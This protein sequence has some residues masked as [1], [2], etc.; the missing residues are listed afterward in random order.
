[1]TTVIAGKCVRRLYELMHKIIFRMKL[2]ILDDNWY[3]MGG[4]CFGLFPPSF[5][6]THTPEEI[7]HITAEK[8]AKLKMMLE[9]LDR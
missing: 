9:E 5:Y 4:N 2:M 3:Y 8:M 1:M 6:C 7:E